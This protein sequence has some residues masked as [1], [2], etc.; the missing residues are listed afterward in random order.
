MTHHTKKPYTR[1]LYHAKLAS[2]LTGQKLAEVAWLGDSREALRAFLDRFDSGSLAVNYNPANLLISGHD[3]YAA[4]TAL[5]RRIAHVDAEDARA[6][7]PNRLA[8]VPLGHGDLDWLQLLAAL[9]Q[10]E[11]RGYLTVTG[12]DP[13][14]FG[15]GVQFL[16]RLTG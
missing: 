8:R 7:S 2:D 14:E 11:Y 16:R 6:V 4:V 3:P 1:A 15:A 10:V 12:A 13:A 9:E 5:G